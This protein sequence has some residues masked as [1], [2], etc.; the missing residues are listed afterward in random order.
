MI[1]IVECFFSFFL[2]SIGCEL[3][4][5]SHC[6]EIILTRINLLGIGFVRM[7]DHFRENAKEEHHMVERRGLFR[8]I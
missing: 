3:M 7:D 1:V 2:S 6:P 8:Y 5:N 4:P